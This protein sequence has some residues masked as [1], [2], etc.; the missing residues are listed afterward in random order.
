MQAGKP[1]AKRQAH[2]PEIKVRCEVP[3]T[4]DRGDNPKQRAPSG[5]KADVQGVAKA[6]VQSGAKADIQRGA[7]A[8][9]QRG[10]KAARK[11]P[12][13]A[14]T[15]KVKA[16]KSPRKRTSKAATAKVKAKQVTAQVTRNCQAVPSPRR[17]VKYN[18]RKPHKTMRS[19]AKTHYFR[20]GSLY[21][22]MRVG[23]EHSPTRRY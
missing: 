12:S 10:A 23:I 3:D 20:H 16:N 11:R 13:K 2:K 19:T 18:G 8:D 7:K 22:M 14:A 21:F 17:V 5:A 1:Q 15:A 9:I 6:D 4:W